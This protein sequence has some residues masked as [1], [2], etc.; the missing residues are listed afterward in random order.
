M[1]TTGL[2]EVP[3]NP[4]HSVKTIFIEM[5]SSGTSYLMIKVYRRGGLYS[6]RIIGSILKGIICKI[7]S[8][9]YPTSVTKN[10]TIFKISLFISKQRKAI[11]LQIQRHTI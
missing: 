6:G 2:P 10:E 8:I 3:S 5:V 9:N 4:N 11:W 7:N 1:W